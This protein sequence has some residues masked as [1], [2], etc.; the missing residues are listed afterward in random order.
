MCRGRSSIFINAFLDLP[1]HV[2]ASHCH[3]QGSW[4][5]RSYSSTLYCGCIWITARPEWSVVPQKLLKQS[6]LWMYMDYGPPKVLSFPSEATR[7]VYIVDVYGLRPAQSA[8]FSFRS[9]LSSLYCGCIWIT[10]RPECLVVPQKLLKQSVLWMY[11]DYGPPRVVSCPSEATRAVYIVDVY[12]LRPVQ[13]AQL[14]RRS[15]TS[16]L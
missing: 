1:Q 9:Y 10:A 12:G 3:H 11:M 16:S 7:A 8:Q 4:F 13:S 14:I 2:S 6:I 5:L 15:Y